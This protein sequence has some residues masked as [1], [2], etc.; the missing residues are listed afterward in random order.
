M[1]SQ[2]G[3]ALIATLLVMVVIVTLGVGSLSLA[4]LDSKIAENVRANA[5]AEASAEAGLSAA[6][7]VLGKQYQ[8]SSEKKFPTTLTIPQINGSAAFAAR[9]VVYTPDADRTGYTLMVK[10]RTVSGGLHQSEVLV[11]STTGLGSTPSTSIGPLGKGGVAEGT[12]TINGSNTRYIDAG[13]HGALGYTLNGY[14]KSQFKKCL[15]RNT[16]TS[17]CQSYASLLTPALTATRDKSGYTCNPSGDSS[18][19]IANKPAQLVSAPPTIV[20]DYDKKRDAA[21]GS[22]T[23]SYSGSPINAAAFVSLAALGQRAVVCVAAGVNFPGGTNL[24][25]VTVIANGDINLNGNNLPIVLNKTVLIS[26]S[27]GININSNDLTIQDSQLFSQ[28]SLNFNGS[29]TKYLGDTTLASKG[30]INVNGSSSASQT[31]DGKR[32]IGLGLIA[33]GDITLNGNSDWYASLIAGGNVNYNGSATL[34]GSVA[35]KR[36]FTANGGLT[37]DASS[38]ISNTYTAPYFEDSAAATP[39]VVS[40]R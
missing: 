37:L 3:V 15:S 31:L 2:R 28:N 10:G 23:N 8:G 38:E 19:C 32:T 29:S 12:I 40:R 9:D 21:M 4:M 34:Y 25:G 5:S 11:V 18:A 27:G 20:V 26:R 13:L 14:D 35:T 24:A 16:T 7:I 22:C 1:K 17:V 30:S 36:G 33:E 6:I 39:T